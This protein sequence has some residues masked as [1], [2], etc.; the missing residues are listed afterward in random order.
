[1]E[2][3]FSQKCLK[4]KKQAE[5]HK[6]LSPLAFI[7]RDD[8]PGLTVRGKI[9]RYFLNWGLSAPRIHKGGHYGKQ[10]CRKFKQAL[11]LI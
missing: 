10:M 11:P 2:K 5:E 6:Q 3:T 4:D 9:P 7:I 1:M 8:S